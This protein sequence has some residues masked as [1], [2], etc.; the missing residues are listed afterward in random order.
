MPCVTNIAKHR[1]CVLF[2]TSLH[3][4]AERNNF[5]RTQ[6]VQGAVSAGGE[7][8]SCICIVQNYPGEKFQL[9]TLVI[10][11]EQVLMCSGMHDPCLTY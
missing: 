9:I 11:I 8:E 10:K 1:K 7:N 4:H 5:G 2:N 3:D 6:N